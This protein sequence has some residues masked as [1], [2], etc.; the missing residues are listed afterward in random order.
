MNELYAIEQ[1][2]WKK[3]AH[4]YSS[5]ELAYK[6]GYIDALLSVSAEIHEIVKEYQTREKKTVAGMGAVIEEFVR[7]TGL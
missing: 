1:D 4:T 6:A 2:N 5:P 7:P 3:P